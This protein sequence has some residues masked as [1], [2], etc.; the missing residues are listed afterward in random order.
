[1]VLVF[2]EFSEVGLCKF[3]SFSGFDLSWWGVSVW[4]SSGEAERSHAHTPALEDNAL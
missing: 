2:I 1:M 3:M 4:C